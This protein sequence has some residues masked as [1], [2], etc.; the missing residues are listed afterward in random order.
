MDSLDYY[1]ND[2][3]TVL[4]DWL[5]KIE[6]G[7]E[8]NVPLRKKKFT[9]KNLQPCYSD[10]LRTQKRMVHRRESIWKKYD[11]EHQ[12]KAFQTEWSIYNRMLNV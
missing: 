1:T 8:D 7:E 3:E 2:L 10:R 5:M 12:W 9:N 11:A 4:I 6:H